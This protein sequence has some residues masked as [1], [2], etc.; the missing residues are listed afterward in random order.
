LSAVQENAA[1]VKLSGTWT[2]Q[3]VAGSFGGSVRWAQTNRDKAQHKFTGTSVMWVTT[4]GPNRGRAT[5]SIDG[6]A[7]VTVDLYAPVQQT[8]VVRFSRTGLA[9]SSH[10]I[11]V[12]VPGQRNA[13]STSNRVD[14]D[15]FI[16]I[17]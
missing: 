10:T 9:A 7:A 11:V 12:Q 15:G 14:V 6:G 16:V 3:V 8:A 17:N 5:V 4:V 2:N 1:A 13:S